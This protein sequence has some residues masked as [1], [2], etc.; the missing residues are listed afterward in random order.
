MIYNFHIF[1]DTN[2]RAIV[3]MDSVVFSQPGTRPPVTEGMDSRSLTVLDNIFYRIVHDING[4]LYEDN[5]DRS[6][7]KDNQTHLQAFQTKPTSMQVETEANEKQNGPLEPL[8]ST[9]QQPTATTVEPRRE[10]VWK[11][12][13]GHASNIRDIARQYERLLDLHSHSG[14]R[15]LLRRYRD[16][17][18][19][20]TYHRCKGYSREEVTLTHAAFDSKIVVHTT[21]SVHEVCL[22]CGEHIAEDLPSMLRFKCHCKQ[23]DDGVSANIQCTKCFTWQHERCSLQLQRDEV[24]HVCKDCQLANDLPL[25]E[26]TV[27]DHPSYPGIPNYEDTLH[28]FPELG[29]KS[30]APPM[31]IPPHVPRQLL[32]DNDHGTTAPTQ[33]S[34]VTTRSSNDTVRR[35]YRTELNHLC[36][37]AGWTLHFD[38]NFTGSETDGTWTSSAYANGVFCGK[39]SAKSTR[40]AR[41]RAAYQAL[42]YYGR[43]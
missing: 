25:P 32:S 33:S 24:V 15:Q 43:A 17:S 4:I 22:I 14:S 3:A 36:I 21:P 40:A 41:D 34:V 10:L 16:F 1:W 29:V 38:D 26:Q 20:Q 39:G 7:N 19:P 2:N 13:Y 9:V 35:H 31:L 27:L 5:L 23:S 11:T 6:G 8:M 18:T 37:Q 28:L 12:A 30:G 42:V